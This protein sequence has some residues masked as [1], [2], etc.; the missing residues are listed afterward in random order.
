MKS[1]VVMLVIGFLLSPISP[2][3]AQDSPL[4]AS[5]PIPTP[6]PYLL[7]FI[8]ASNDPFWDSF[9]QSLNQ[10]S[11]NP[12]ILRRGER[13][14]LIEQGVITPETISQEAITTP[15]LW[16]TYQQYGE[17]K[18][19]QDWLAFPAQ[20]RLDL[21]VNRQMWAQM[22][23]MQQYRFVNRFGSVARQYGYELRV[24][25]SEPRCLALYSCNY[26]TLPDPP[27][28]QVNLR[29]MQRNPFNF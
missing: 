7:E 29:P 27:Q 25:N 8:P 3:I 2:T 20:K 5:P 11:I 28:C 10:C 19:L 24:F 21:V 18:L 4:A 1:S 26:S 17:G 23:Y 16:W 15:S 22:D 6:N 13:E 9:T 14:N 12:N